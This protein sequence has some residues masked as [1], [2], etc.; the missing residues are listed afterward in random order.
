MNVRNSTPFPDM[1][2]P[3][4]GE[5]LPESYTSSKAREQ[6]LHDEQM[7]RNVTGKFGQMLM[8]LFK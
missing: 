2:D 3:V 6:A 4:T 5:W 1:R 8:S 7:A